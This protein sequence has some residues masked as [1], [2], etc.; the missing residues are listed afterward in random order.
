[1]A[2]LEVLTE[3]ICPE[4]FLGLVTLSELMNMVQM[5]GTSLPVWGVVWEFLPTVPAGIVGSRVG[6]RLMKRGLG[7]G[8]G[9]ARPRVTTK[10]QG[11]LMPLR[12]ILVLEA[13]RA[14]LTLVLLLRLMH[15]E[16]WSALGKP[17]GLREGPKK[18]TEALLQSRTSLAS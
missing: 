2:V 1:V 12:L 15:P 18:L 5:A 16:C 7:P 9:G 13:V 4:E 10:V 8:Q 14:V 3:V 17:V 11:V 6:R